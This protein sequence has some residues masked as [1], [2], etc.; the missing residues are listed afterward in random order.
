M[1]AKEARIKTEETIEEKKILQYA[2][3]EE[4]IGAYIERG[5][6]QCQLFNLYQNTLFEENRQHL[7]DDGYIVNKE[8]S[9]WVVS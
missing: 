3:I 2:Q 5:F 4:Q 7:I 8:S 9:Y 6:F 1:N